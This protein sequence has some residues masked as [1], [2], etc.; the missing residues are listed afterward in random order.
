WRRTR[1]RRRPRP[2]RPRRGAHARHPAPRGRPADPPRVESSRVRS[3]IRRP[4]AG[5]GGRRR[6]VDRAPAPPGDHLR[7]RDSTRACHARVATRPNAL[8]RFPD[9][10]RASARHPAMLFY[11]DNWLSARPDFTVPAGGPKGGRK[12]GL[13]ENYARELMELHTLGVD[14]GYTQTDVAEV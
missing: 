6:G 13:N 1:V 10:V 5:A 4:R 9:L 3:A 2:G 12:A 11:L 8:G 7:R 14:G